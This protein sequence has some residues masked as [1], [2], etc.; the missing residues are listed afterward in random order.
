[1]V[2]AAM[3]KPNG[4]MVLLI[5]LNRAC[6]NDLQKRKTWIKATSETHRE[7]LEPF[8][9][10]ELVIEGI[11]NEADM[12]AVLQRLHPDAPSWIHPDLNS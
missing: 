11:N 12:L 10:D 6:F 4:K 3:K 1:M 7:S 2:I 8:G 9:I 5:G